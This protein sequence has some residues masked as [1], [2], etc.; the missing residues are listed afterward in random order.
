MWDLSHTGDEG[1]GPEEG[2]RERESGL[3]LPRS[4]GLLSRLRPSTRVTR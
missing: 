2:G 4:L 1:R 3:D